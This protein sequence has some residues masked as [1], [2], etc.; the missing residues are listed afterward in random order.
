MLGVVR[1]SAAA[2]SRQ[3]STTT[4]AGQT[5]GVCGAESAVTSFFT[6]GE[7]IAVLVT[8]KAGG[9]DPCLMIAG[10]RLNG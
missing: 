4:T 1:K 7:A 10:P 3:C 9:L 6:R 8:F 5:D 2:F